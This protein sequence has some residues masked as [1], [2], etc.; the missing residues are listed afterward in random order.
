M[1]GDDDEDDEDAVVVVV[2]VLRGGRGGGA[3][4]SLRSS[5][6][7][8]GRSLGSCLGDAVNRCIIDGGGS[9]GS[10]ARPKGKR[11]ILFVCMRQWLYDS[12]FAR[13]RRARCVLEML[14]TSR[15]NVQNPLTDRWRSNAIHMVSES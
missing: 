12:R 6:G 7:R 15:T 3:E 10:A 8:S 13:L 1:R 2:V 11:Q 9:A 4:S 14:L 5:T